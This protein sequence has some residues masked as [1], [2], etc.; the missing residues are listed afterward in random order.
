[1]SRRLVEPKIVVAAARFG[2]GPDCASARQGS[3][4]GCRPLRLLRAPPRA[5]AAQPVFARQVSREEPTPR[6]PS[7]KSRRRTATL[8][9]P[10]ELMVA[11]NWAALVGSGYL[12]PQVVRPRSSHAT[13]L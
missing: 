13:T 3:A 4:R 11:A 5:R 2:F 7:T 8:R 12:A 1:M 10:S 6:L 9:R